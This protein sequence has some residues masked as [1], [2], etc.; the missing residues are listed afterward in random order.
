M[1]ARQGRDG[2]VRSGRLPERF[3][4]WRS[5]RVVV[6]DESMTP[7][8]F[9]GDRLLIDPAAYRRRL[10]SVGELVVLIDPEAPERWLIKRVRAVDPTERT[11]DVRGDAVER[12]RDSRRFGPVPLR[13]LVGRAYR[14]YFPRE[15]AR[16][17]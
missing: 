2:S 9:P 11:V 1:P 4:R 14:I 5:R 8:L 10:P 13:S 12:A 17:L 7:T 6:A 3:R 16:E 15:R